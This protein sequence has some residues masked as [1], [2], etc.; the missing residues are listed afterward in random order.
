MGEMKI[1]VYMAVSAYGGISKELDAHVGINNP[2]WQSS[3]II[4]ILC[5][6]YIVIVIALGCV[7]LAV[8]SENILLHKIMGGEAGT[9]SA[10][11]SLPLSTALK[12]EKEL[13]RLTA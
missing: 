3:G 10:P 6:Y 9:P 4:I 12:S 5:K 13:K 8:I 7:F 11:P 1:F 2:C